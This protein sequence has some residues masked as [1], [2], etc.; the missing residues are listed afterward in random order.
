MFLYRRPMNMDLPTQVLTLLYMGMAALFGISPASVPAA[1]PAPESAEVCIDMMSGRENPCWT[2]SSEETA[3]L[4]ETVDKST[5]TEWTKPYPD[6][7]G[8]RGMLVHV[9][10]P[11]VLSNYEFSMPIMVSENIV[12]YP[13]SMR[14]AIDSRT[15][16]FEPNPYFT[17]KADPE[18]SFEQ[19][20]LET[21]KGK[22]DDNLLNEARKAL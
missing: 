4:L 10:A 15:Y 17:Y 20:L 12:A 21:G 22:I 1:I 14:Y 5:S 3:Q 8:Y 16:L 13:T 6:R 11:N 19:W 9:N 2:I 18:R 7:L